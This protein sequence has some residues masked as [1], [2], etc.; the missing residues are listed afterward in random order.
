MTSMKKEQSTHANN[1]SLG[2]L[3]R[4]PQE[5]GSM[6]W[7]IFDINSGDVLDIHKVKIPRTA[8]TARGSRNTLY[9]AYPDRKLRGAH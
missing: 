4:A 7:K 3:F 2:V 8:L 1:G 9:I 6:E 5:K